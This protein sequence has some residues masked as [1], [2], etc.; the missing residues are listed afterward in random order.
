MRLTLTTDLPSLLTITPSTL[1]VAKADWNSV[2]QTITVKALQGQ[3]GGVASATI[4]VTP[5][6]TD[7]KYN[8]TAA[9]T[10]KTAAITVTT[11]TAGWMNIG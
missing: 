2:A 8:A 11:N 6:S 1:T 5:E 4:T 3:Y 7:P 9:R 10:T